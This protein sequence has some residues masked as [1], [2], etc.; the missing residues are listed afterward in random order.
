MAPTRS[1]AA[2]PERSNPARMAKGKSNKAASVMRSAAK[3]SGGRSRS[4]SLMNSHVEPHRTQQASQASRT[5]ALTTGRCTGARPAG[6]G[7]ISG[8]REVAFRFASG[9]SPGFIRAE[10]SAAP[11]VRR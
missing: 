1:A 6:Q 11:L 4:P 9:E 5:R 10:K 3:R 7:D 8:S 2:R